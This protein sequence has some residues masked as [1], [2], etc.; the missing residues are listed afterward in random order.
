MLLR[1]LLSFLLGNVAAG[2]GLFY[3]L[4]EK[5]KTNIVTQEKLTTKYYIVQYIV[6]FAMFFALSYVL[7]EDF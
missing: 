6:V 3:K 5:S 4:K 1:I 7:L 2:I